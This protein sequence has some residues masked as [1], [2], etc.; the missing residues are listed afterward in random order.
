VI[1][2][3]TPTAAADAVAAALALANGEVD[4]EVDRLPALLI[5]AAPAALPGSNARGGDERPPYPP[6]TPPPPPDG[7][8]KGDLYE[9]MRLVRCV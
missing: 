7:E 1:N 4:L 8:K 2:Q 9:V 5:P 6:K 3:C